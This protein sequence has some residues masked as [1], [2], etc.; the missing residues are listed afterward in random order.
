M[1]MPE[2]VAIEGNIGSAKSTLIRAF[3]AKQ[4]QQRQR[5]VVLEE[6]VHTWHPFLKAFYDAPSA[7]TAFGLQM[8]IL[9]S[10]AE[11]MLSCADVGSVVV[12]ER[13][14]DSSRDVFMRKLA[15]DA[16]LDRSRLDTYNA[17]DR[18]LRRM[19]ANRDRLVGVVYLDVTP[20]TC[21]ERARQRCRESES[22]LTLTYLRELEIAY[23]VWL[24]GLRHQGVPVTVL[25]VSGTSLET[26]QEAF[27]AAGIQSVEAMLRLTDTPRIE[28]RH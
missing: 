22:S 2:F 21:F 3:L 8:E 24:Q 13:C 23:A 16:I 7:D 14:T 15:D 18:L 17:W 4:Q 6:P 28:M 12:T 11:Q 20:E 5:N 10:R 9:R 1:N 26:D 19:S 25:N 27:E